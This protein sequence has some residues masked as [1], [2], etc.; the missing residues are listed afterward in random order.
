MGWCVR[1]CGWGQGRVCGSAASELAR[2]NCGRLTVKRFSAML[3]S[4]TQNWWFSLGR[5]PEVVST[6]FATCD[7]IPSTAAGRGEAGAS[8]S[9]SMDGSGSEPTAAGG[10]RSVGCGCCSWSCCCCCCG[11]TAGRR[12]RGNEDIYVVHK[13]RVRLLAQPPPLLA[14][15]DQGPQQWR[16]TA[17]RQAWHTTP[18]GLG[19][20]WYG[21][22]GSVRGGRG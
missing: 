18:H 9:S 17:E 13:G 5:R 11:G 22:L 19:D 20:K 6:H 7:M 12:G 8:P 10:G 4:L 16:D 21:I 15:A 14:S 2:Q 1:V 3:E